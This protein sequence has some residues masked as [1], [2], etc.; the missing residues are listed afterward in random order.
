M[1]RVQSLKELCQSVLRYVGN[2]YVYYKT[3]LVP[4]EKAHKTQQILKKVS[5][6]Y[7]T[8]LSQG[9]RQ[10]NRKRGI[11]NYQVVSFRGIIIILR[12]YSFN[13]VS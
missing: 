13:T 9:K 10:Y 5:E 7:E 8:D 4:L 1:Y 3:A 6:A 12:T 2:G 11:A